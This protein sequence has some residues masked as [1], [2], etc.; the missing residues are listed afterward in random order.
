[1]KNRWTLNA[2]FLGVM[3]VS[4]VIPCLAQ[5]PKMKMTTTL[6]PGIATPDKV[7]TRLGTLNFFDG[8]PD[9]ATV[10]KLYDNLDFQRAVQAYL[11]AIP[12]VSQAANRNEILKLGPANT[13]VPIFENR[14]DSKSTFLTPNTQ[15]PYS[16]MWLDLRGG[17]LVLEAPPKVL[18]TLNDM[19]YRWVADI[20][21]TGPDKGAGG[22]FLILPPA[23]KGEVPPGYFV[24]RS[25]TYSLWAPWRSFVV[26]GDPK[27]GVDLVKNHTRV[28]RLSEASNPPSMKFVNVSGKAFST[29]A[30]GDYAFWE[31]LNQVVQEEPSESIDPIR[32]GFFASIGIEKGKPFEPDARMKKV[33]AEAASVGDATAR[34]IAFRTRQKEAFYYPGSFWQLPFIGGYKFQTQPGVLN[35]D[36]YIYYYFMATGV[37]PAMEEKMVGQGSQYAWTAKDANGAPLNGSKTYK[38]HLPS[39]IPVKNFWSVIVYDNQARS[40]VQTDQQFPSMGSQDKDLVVNKDGSVDIY[41]GTKKPAGKVNWIQ[42]VPGKGWNTI[43]RLYSPLEPW[44]NKTWRPGEIEEVK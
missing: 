24:V 10:D 18:G 37:T 22:K 43:L 41:F 35:M 21:F 40:M 12:A 39:N 1:M 14:M 31:L 11:L 6:P 25:P 34:A 7:E 16:W 20:G 17:P 36:A 15:T 4:L 23:Y 29:V 33:L 2:I 19:W 38:L 3:V 26:N 28:Y 30:P 44:F 8:F 32:L 5:V 27:P 9:K 42:T 13:T